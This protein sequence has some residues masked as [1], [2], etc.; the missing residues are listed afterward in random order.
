MQQQLNK[1]TDLVNSVAG[2]V[3]QYVL[4]AAVAIVV[5]YVV[6]KVWRRRKRN[7]VPSAA[8]LRI[9][10]GS[11]SQEGPP[12]GPPVLEFYHTPVRLAAIVLAPAGRVRDLPDEDQL[13]RLFDSILPGLAK[14]AA[15]QQPAIF[16]WPNQVSARGFAHLVFNH[17]RLP[18]DGGKG[19][20]WSSVAGIFKVQNQPVVAGLILRAAEPNNFGQVI[21]EAEH[22]WLGCLR[23]TRG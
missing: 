17:V 5:L 2:G 10:I 11:L 3:L 23:V 7:A 14:V 19:S 1:L 6:W 4:P 22:Q 8:D 13:P 18:G 12:P 21:I 15:A 16:R 9:E 20:A